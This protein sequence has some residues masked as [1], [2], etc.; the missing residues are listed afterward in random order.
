MAADNICHSN[1]PLCTQAQLGFTPT[2]M[3]FLRGRSSSDARAPKQSLEKA[4]GL[5]TPEFYP[6]APSSTETIVWDQK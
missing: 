2:K 6:T 5:N 3:K 1:F 4:P